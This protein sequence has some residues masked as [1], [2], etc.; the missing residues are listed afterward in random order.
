MDKVK[1]LFLCT[2]N[3]CR[4]Q[5]AE[6]WAKKLRDSEIMILSHIPPELKSMGLILL[7]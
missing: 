5:I 1:V 7:P 6:G 4:S 2:G 3:S